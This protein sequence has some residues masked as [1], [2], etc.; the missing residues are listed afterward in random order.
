MNQLVR[1]LFS[2]LVF[3]QLNRLSVQGAEAT[4]GADGTIQQPSEEVMT[5]SASLIAKDP[6]LKEDAAL[7]LA[8][9]IAEVKND[10]QTKDMLAHMVQD[11][12]A[13]FAS[14]S[15][16]K[17]QELVQQ[18]SKG[19]EELKMLEV[20]FKDPARAVRLMEEEGMIP[21]DAIG[22]YREDPAL[23]EADTRKGMYFMFVAV[24]S[25]AGFL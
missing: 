4:V 23:L 16:M 9:L 13:E 25:A 12:P 21:A 24:A 18:L 19:F 14:I 2:M 5:I 20:L 22:K 10:K 6:T 17:P 1:L 3:L 8:N 7:D 15:Q 11:N